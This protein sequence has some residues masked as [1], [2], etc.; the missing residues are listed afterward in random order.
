MTSLNFKLRLDPVKQLEARKRLLSQVKRQVE[1]HLGVTPSSILK[2]S[3]AFEKE[4][5]AKFFASSKDELLE[6]I[7][8]A[9][10]VFAAD[11]HAFSQAQRTHLKILRSLPP[12]FSLTLALEAIPVE[13]NNLVASYLAGKTSE[14]SFLKKVQ[15]KKRWGF[16]WEHY[17]PLFQI[18]KQ[19]QFKII[20]LNKRMLNSEE[21]SQDLQMRDQF[22]ARILA[23]EIKQNPGILIYAVFGELH[24]AQ[25]HLP[26]E[27]EHAFKK[28]LKFVQ[29][30]QNLEK[31][32]FRL[33]ER[34]EEGKVDVVKFAKNRFVV[35]ASPPW[36]QWQSYLMFLDST[37]DTEL[38][39]DDSGAIDFTDQVSSLVNVLASDLKLNFKVNDLAIYSCLDDKIW[40]A[41]AKSLSSAEIKVAERNIQLGKCFFLPGLGVGYLG[42]ASVNQAAEVAGQFIHAKLCHRR[43]LF[44]KMPDDFERMIWV[45]AVGYF[46]SKMLNPK[47][48]AQTMTDL[49]MEL[50]SSNSQSREIL[51]LA[52]AQRM[53]EIVFVQLGRRRPR[54]NLPRQESRFEP[55]ARILGDMM[56]ERLFL[57]H[58]SNRVKKGRLM[59]WLKHSIEG[60]DF[61]SFYA[62]VV[63]ELEP[64]SHRMRSKKERL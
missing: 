49:R 45:K 25:A 46:L 55:A 41:L 38:E 52:L 19:R 14:S 2:Y 50:E 33:S 8:R 58:H 36:V 24:V 10:I 37:A 29:I 35:N 48:Q 4:A 31:V 59:E 42:R 47:R 64:V 40:K 53:R 27:T 1:G 9:Q 56:G 23:R 39:I 51:R 57:A 7:Q 62:R 28:K 20:G 5:R 32:Y 18:A 15:W 12:D 26:L 43:L 13:A 54:K 6:A 30:Y 21:R 16:P 60:Q 61:H 22:A 63:A 44:G 3:E 34:G 11:F 17:R